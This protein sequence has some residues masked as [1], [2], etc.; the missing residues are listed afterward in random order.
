MVYNE[1][2]KATSSKILNSFNSCW[3]QMGME[4]ASIFPLLQFG[5]AKEVKRQVTFYSTDSAIHWSIILSDMKALN[6]LVG[7][8]QNKGKYVPLR[9]QSEETSIQ[10]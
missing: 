8:L 7:T 5:K 3:S 1:S 2:G 4:I 9:T 10:K 6:Y